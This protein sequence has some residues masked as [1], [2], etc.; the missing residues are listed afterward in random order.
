MT[1]MIKRFTDQGEVL[2]DLNK[3][4]TPQDYKP[5]YVTMGIAAFTICF[6]VAAIVYAI[7]N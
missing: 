4:E 7:T 5:I 1:E 2:E 3:T 6:V